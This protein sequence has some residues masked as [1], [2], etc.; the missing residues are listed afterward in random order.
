[1]KRG[2]QNK[3]IAAA[4]TVL[5]MSLINTSAQ[6]ELWQVALIGIGIYEAALLAVQIAR[7]EAR[8]QRRKRYITASKIDMQR[9]A[10]QVFNPLRNMKEVS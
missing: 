5:F 3:I 4:G 8:K 9:V 6:P 7:K 10:G 1:M 2:A